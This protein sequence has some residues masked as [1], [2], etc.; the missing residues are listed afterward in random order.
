MF[1]QVHNV[2]LQY[3]YVAPNNTNYHIILTHQKKKNSN[4]KVI[5][6]KEKGKYK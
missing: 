4:I 1:S 2:P 6:S 5:S 3:F